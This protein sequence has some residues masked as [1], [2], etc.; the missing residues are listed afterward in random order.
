MEGF[1][2]CLSD[3]S[4]Q[5]SYKIDWKWYRA[6]P[7]A[8]LDNTQLLSRLMYI[9]NRVSSE[10]PTA[11]RLHSLDDYIFSLLVEETRRTKTLY[12]GMH[13]SDEIGVYAFLRSRKEGWKKCRAVSLTV[14]RGVAE[15]FAC[16][17]PGVAFQVVLSVDPSLI[18]LRKVN[19]SDRAGADYEPVKHIP[20]GEMR[21][22][23]IPLEAVKRTAVVY[24][25][26]ANKRRREYQGL[27]DPLDVLLDT[28][29]RGVGRESVRCSLE[30][31]LE[32]YISFLI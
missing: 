4:P 14:F 3:S 27:P 28:S 15:A 25:S 17:Y 10:G 19:Y 1:P 6:E 20:G 16:P 21:T 11:E 26:D 8:G 32:P 2:A 23:Y 31:Q 24:A 18:D 12:Q 30:D 7:S 22:G 9:S 29:R 13:F 5:D